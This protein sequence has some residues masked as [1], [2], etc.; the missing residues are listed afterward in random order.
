MNFCALAGCMTLPMSNLLSVPVPSILPIQ[1]TAAI[2]S[3]TSDFCRASD[4]AL[5][6]TW[7]ANTREATSL[8]ARAMVA[9]WRS[10]ASET[11]FE[12]ASCALEG[13]LMLAEA[14]GRRGPCAA[15]EEVAFGRTRV[16]A[17]VGSR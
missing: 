6:T 9:A 5:L 16:S 1:T 7:R 8:T 12:F 11:P 10:S 15:S 4:T 17:L 3:S 13:S 14:E 2:S